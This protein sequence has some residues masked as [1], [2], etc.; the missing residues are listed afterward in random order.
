VYIHICMCIHMYAHT[1][2]VHCLFIC[3][4]VPDSIMYL[5]QIVSQWT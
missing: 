5:L 4:W 3:W 2:Y 1:M